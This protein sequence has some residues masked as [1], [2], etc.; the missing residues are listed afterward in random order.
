MP[1]YPQEDDKL[2]ASDLETRRGGNTPNT[3]EVL[4]QLIQSGH[5]DTTRL[6]LI[7]VLPARDSSASE[8]IR[9]SLPD[10]NSDRCLYREDATEAASSYIIKSQATGSRTIVN[11]NELDEMTV[12]EFQGAVESIR[13]MPSDQWFHFEVH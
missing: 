6:N 8:H 13:D 11:Y 10:V 1:A 5:D 12:A 4:Q 2:R 7:S 3:L 9:S